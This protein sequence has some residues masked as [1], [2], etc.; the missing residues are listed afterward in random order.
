M[1]GS[2]LKKQHTIE[3]IAIGALV[4]AAIIISIA[5]FKKGDID[6]EVFS[7]KEFNNKWKEVEILEANVPNEENK[8]SYIK[9][10]LIIV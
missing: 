2:A 1:A 6:D 10:F 4:V 5:R 8:I 7:R 3:Y 9:Y